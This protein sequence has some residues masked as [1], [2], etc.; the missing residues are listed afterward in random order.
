VARYVRHPAIANS[1]ICG[2]NGKE[3]TFWYVDRDDAKRYE[4][5]FDSSRK[6]RLGHQKNGLLVLNWTIGT[7]SVLAE[8]LLISRRVLFF[9]L[10]FFG[11]DIRVFYV[12]LF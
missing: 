5:M 6:I 8:T 9:L 4:T 2:Y 3:V 1:R 12:L 11:I 10:D 7:T